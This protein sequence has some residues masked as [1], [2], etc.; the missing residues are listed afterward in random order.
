MPQ[1][2]IPANWTFR[3]T[4]DR[5]RVMR[6]IADARKRQGEWPGEQLFWDLH[7]VA[8]WLLDKLMVRFGRHQA[9]VI[10]TRDLHSDE[11]ILLFQGIISNKRSQPVINDWFGLHSE[12]GSGWMVVN[13][14][15]TVGLTGFDN[16][17]SNP[18]QPS[19]QIDLIRSQLPEAV[20]TA[21]THMLALRTERAD[22]ERRRL[23]ED[24]RRLKRWH[25]ATTKRIQ[26]QLADARGS[27]RAR[28]QHELD[29][30]DKISRRRQQWLTETF[31]SDPT[32]YL[33]LAAV[34]SG[35]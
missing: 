4:T 12:G 30:A 35:S 14:A 7:P 15:E 20:K 17:L 32:P 25:Q 10:L 5:E 6:A 26:A 18:G 33:R 9:P 16:G 31:T 1:E 34:F 8:E 29:E 21:Q 13:W 2:A 11:T 28:Y 23:Q 22:A 19:Q 27:R 24:L 3:L